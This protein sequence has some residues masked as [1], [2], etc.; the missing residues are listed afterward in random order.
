MLGLSCRAAVLI[1]LCTFAA[2][3]DAAAEEKPV[4]A[5][6]PASPA[7]YSRAHRPRSSIRLVVVH[8]AEGSYWGT[9]AWFRNPRARASAHYVVSRDERVARTVPDSHVAWHA[10][11]AYVNRHS[12]GIEHEG[13]TWVP[14]TFTDAEYRASA[15]L[16]ASLLRRYLLPIDRRRVIGHNE[17]PD[18]G[19]P[20]AFGGFSNHTDPGRYWDWRRYMSYIRSYV[21]RRSPP[22]PTFDVTI[23][24]LALGETVRGA[25]RWEAVTSGVPPT[26]VEFRIDGRLRHTAAEPPYLFG[27][28]GGTWDTTREKNGRRVLSVHAVAP[29]GR[30]AHSSVVV[31]VKNAPQPQPPPAPRILAVSVGEGQTLFGPVRWEVL[32]TGRVDRVEFLVDGV[33]RD[34]QR[35][36]PYVFGGVTGA[37][38][39]TRETPGPHALTVR[40]VG[41]QEVATATINV[42][43]VA[44]PP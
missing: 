12:L 31:K 41:V 24:D 17:V 37:W 5:V 11:N 21:R 20:G 6:V 40:A 13:F 7:N 15:R 42:I 14:W 10:G 32:V 27:G 43:V 26:R 39:T 25:V 35:R 28:A 44:P 4:A 33:L 2:V 8:V 19:R 16:T 3:G 36:A 23:P 29:D 1:A 18:P 30:V 22:P 34:T 38:D 9:I